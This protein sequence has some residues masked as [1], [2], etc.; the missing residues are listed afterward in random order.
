MAGGII[1]RWFRPKAYIPLEEHRGEVAFVVAQAAA[2]ENDLI[3]RN[4]GMTEQF[5]LLYSDVVPRVDVRQLCEEAG[6]AAQQQMLKSLT[7]EG[8]YGAVHSNYFLNLKRVDAAAWLRAHPFDLSQM[9]PFN[10]PD[11]EEEFPIKVEDNI[12]VPDEA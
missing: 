12:L 1:T 7:D 5:N 8:L 2:R 10:M 9:F 11:A 4:E 3:V 6:R